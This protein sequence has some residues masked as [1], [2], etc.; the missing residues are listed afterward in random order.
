MRLRNSNKVYLFLT[1][2]K[3]IRETSREEKIKIF[4]E[5]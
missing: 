5:E 2:N 1:I 4:S 3:V